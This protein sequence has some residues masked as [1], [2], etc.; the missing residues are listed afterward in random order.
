LLRSQVWN[1]SQN[2]DRNVDTQKIGICM[3][4]TPSMI[5]YITNRGGPMVGLEAL[6]MQGLPID[7]LLLTRETEDQLADLAGNAMSTTVVGACILAIL[8][9]GK[10][11]L[12]SGHDEVD[13]PKS[14]AADG[15]DVDQPSDTPTVEKGIVGEDQLVHKPLDLSATSDITLARLLADAEKSSRL[16]QCEGRLDMTDRQVVRCS[17]CGSASCQKCAGR[18]EHNF[19]PIDLHAHPRLSASAFGKELKS[20]LPMCISLANVTEELL[21]NLRDSAE[22]TISEK[23]WKAWRAAVMRVARFELRFVEPKRQEIW[24]AV[25]QSPT[26]TLELLIHP[27]QPEWRLYAKPED[28]E[29]ANSEIRRVLELP[30]ARL[31]CADGLLSGRFEFALPFQTSIPITVE[32][33]G[34]LVP[35]WEARLGLTAEDFKDR[36]VHSKV[37]MTVADDDVSKLDRDIS[38]VYVLLDKCG[39]ANGALHRNVEETGNTPPL[40]LLLDPSRCGDPKQDCFVVSISQRRYQYGESRPIICKLDTSWRQSDQDDAQAVNCHIPVKWVATRIAK[41][42]VR[43]RFWNVVRDITEF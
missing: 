3:C 10:K 9:V 4:L 18:P 13:E 12:K 5:P 29:P 39:T 6:S 37:K 21:D 30:I 16:C 7:K 27:Q 36:V 41:L 34:D 1:L 22:V 20:T 35:S 28:A 23:R 15:M 19:Q 40:F 33:M 38:G 32:G 2:V 11:L 26:S 8:V 31:S 24:T 17:D 25:Y 42:Q 43:S 14:E